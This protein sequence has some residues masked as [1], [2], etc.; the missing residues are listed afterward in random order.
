LSR[1][2]K[3]NNSPFWQYTT[4]TEPNRIRLSTKTGNKKAAV[5]RQKEWDLIY[6]QGQ[7]TI[8]PKSVHAFIDSYLIWHKANKS[9]AWHTRVKQ[10]LNHFQSMYRT[11][12]LSFID[13]EHI[14]AYKDK[15]ISEGAKGNTINHE[16]SMISG[17]Y[18][19]AMMRRVTFTNPADSYF[20]ARI[21]TSQDTRQP[22]PINI[23]KDIIIN[24]TNPKDKA[25]YSIALYSGMRSSDAGNLSQMNIKNDCLD[26]IQG[27]VG[28]RC[29]V[30]LHPFLSNLNLFELYKTKSQRNRMT[31]RLKI[32]LKIH[33]CE[34]D[35]HS[36]RHTFAASLEN[37]GMDYMEIKFLMGHSMSDVTWRY[38]SK[39][40]KKYAGFI[41]NI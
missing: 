3:P 7:H 14:Q 35:Y 28:R 12:H 24:E 1:L 25:M 41:K 32:K 17:L 20:I 22:I 6:D 9:E 5:I 37:Q 26:F 40:T 11:L 18:K 39:S 13:I 16:L 33:N 19:Y 10:G 30:P 2:R 29:I 4:G 31:E 27:K 34:G 15:R 8:Q 38:L 36:I 23:I 21:D